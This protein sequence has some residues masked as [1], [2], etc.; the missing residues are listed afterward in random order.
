MEELYQIEV[1]HYQYCYYLSEKG[2]LIE[3]FVDTAIGGRGA[4][5]K[6]L[7]ETKEYIEKY[8]KNEKNR[9]MLVDKEHFFDFFPFKKFP[10][11]YFELGNIDYY[12]YD[13][14]DFKNSN[15]VFN[16]DE[17][18]MKEVKKFFKE[19]LL[20]YK[21]KKFLNEWQFIQDYL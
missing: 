21:E 7:K 11:I 13:E 8:I 2:E 15:E 5:N 4:S 10:V 9:F 19:T 20:N 3:E 6:T 14:I 12:I 17:N 18:Q 1:Y 16:L